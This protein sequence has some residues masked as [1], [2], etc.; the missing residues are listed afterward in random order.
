MSI[1]FTGADKLKKITMI[2]STLMLT[3]LLCEEGME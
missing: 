1:F 3:I 2:D